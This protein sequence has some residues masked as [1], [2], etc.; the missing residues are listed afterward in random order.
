MARTDPGAESFEWRRGLS[1]ARVRPRSRKDPNS[2]G[3]ETGD[4]VKTCGFPGHMG[5][6]NQFLC[7]TMRGR[8]IGWA[9]RG[10]CRGTWDG[11]GRWGGAGIAGSLGTF[12]CGYTRYYVRY[13][14]MRG[15]KLYRPG[16]KDSEGFR[17]P[18]GASRLPGEPRKKPTRIT[19][20][21]T[22]IN[23][24]GTRLG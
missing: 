23:Q 1:N 11:K 5:R 15:M 10:S 6:W 19:D 8:V 13:L 20:L 16:R 14:Y 7:V 3:G 2:S 22:I 4:G 12:I 24:R 9:G 17:G 18:V 21:R